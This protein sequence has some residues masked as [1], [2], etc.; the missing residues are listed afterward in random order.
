MLHDTAAFYGRCVSKDRK[1]PRIVL[2]C[3]S[4]FCE[5]G[6]CCGSACRGTCLSCALTGTG[7]T[8][9]TVPAGQDPLD[10]CSDSG[11][12]SCATDGTCNGNVLYSTGA[13]GVS[14]A[15][16]QTA[17]SSNTSVKVSVSATVS[18][19]ATYTS[20]DAN[21]SGSTSSC[22]TTSLTINNN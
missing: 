17:I 9:S 14:G 4:A 12:A 2:D 16:P 1:C 7:G 22:E 5:Q 20:N 19:K 3:A 21:V 13:M 10:Q 6:V 15:S 8:C 11:A 18:W